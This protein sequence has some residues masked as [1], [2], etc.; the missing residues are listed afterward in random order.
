MANLNIKDVP[1]KLHRRLKARARRNRRSLNREVIALLEEATGPQRVDDAEW[2]ERARD[3]RRRINL[4][5]TD[6]EIERA[7]ESGRK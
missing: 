4:H 7:I 1:E 6:E 2:L 3:L 5:L